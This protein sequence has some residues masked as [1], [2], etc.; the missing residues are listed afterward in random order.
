MTTKIDLN[1]SMFHAMFHDWTNA[2]PVDVK[3][4][5]NSETFTVYAVIVGSGV[6]EW[7]K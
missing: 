1:T 5:L 7:M 2:T 3:I 4:K 6:W